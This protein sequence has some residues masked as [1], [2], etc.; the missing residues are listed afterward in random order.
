[1][2]D[3]PDF[4]CVGVPKAGTGWLFD[5]LN[6]HPDFWMPPVKESFTS[7]GISRV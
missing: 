4:L 5:Q 6:A 3:G 1:M 7:A 2:H